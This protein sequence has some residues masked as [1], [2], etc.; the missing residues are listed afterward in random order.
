M[1]E[2]LI[3]IYIFFEIYLALL[4]EKIKKGDDKNDKKRN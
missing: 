1:I 3:N 4:Q 2:K